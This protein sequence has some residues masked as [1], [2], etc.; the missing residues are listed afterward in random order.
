LALAGRPGHSA[1]LVFGL[2]LLAAL[3][4]SVVHSSQHGYYRAARNRVK[5]VERMFD[6]PDDARVDT[7]GALGGRR[8]T[9]KVTTVVNLLLWA[10]AIAHAVGIFLVLTG[11]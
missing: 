5:R 11:S 2:G 7:T 3:L 1:A 4:S 6:V 9:V 8:V 10:M